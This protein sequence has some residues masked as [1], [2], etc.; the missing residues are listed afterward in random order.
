MFSKTDIEKYFIAE[1]QESILFL[2][3][4]IAAVAVSL[5]FFFALKTGFYKGAAIPL[6]VV[7]LLGIVGYSVYKRSDGNRI[8]N[9]YAHDMNPSEL[10]QKE[11]PR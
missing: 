9:V 6:V 7:G 10:K 5:I 3:I 1:K 2:L 4:G 11:L 8:R